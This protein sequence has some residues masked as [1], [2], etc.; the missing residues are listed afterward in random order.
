M[1]VA[2]NKVM[3]EMIQEIQKLSDLA[4]ILISQQPVTPEE[5][6]SWSKDYDTTIN[7]LNE[8]KIETFKSFG[9]F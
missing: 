8:L 5:L 4:R 7:R 2:K 3:L 1:T 9:R 6:G